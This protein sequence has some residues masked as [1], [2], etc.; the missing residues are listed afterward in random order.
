MKP[1]IQS[2]PVLD[3]WSKVVL[4]NRWK[5]YWLNATGQMEDKVFWTWPA[6]LDFAMEQVAEASRKNHLH[7]W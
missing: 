4:I 2:W 6:A 1:R 3:C 5:V 7:L